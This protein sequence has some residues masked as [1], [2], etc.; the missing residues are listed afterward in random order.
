MGPINQSRGVFKLAHL[1]PS[2]DYNLWSNY[3]YRSLSKGRVEAT[4]RGFCMAQ[5]VIQSPQT[6]VDLNCIDFL[7][8]FDPN[9]FFLYLFYFLSH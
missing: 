8:F 6:R 1:C 3:V 4:R 7:Y 2:S 9:S 5:F